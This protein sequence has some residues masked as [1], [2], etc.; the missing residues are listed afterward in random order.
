MKW[1]VILK[2]DEAKGTVVGVMLTLAAARAL[3]TK[4]AANG[5]EVEIWMGEKLEGEL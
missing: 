4:W 2:S 1:L 3:Y 5:H